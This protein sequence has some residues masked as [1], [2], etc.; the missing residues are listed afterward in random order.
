VL[1]ILKREYWRAWRP[2]SHPP[3][4]PP[5]CVWSPGRKGSLLRSSRPCVTSSSANVPELT[6]RL[7]SMTTQI[8]RRPGVSLCELM[9]HGFLREDDV[10][11][12][13]NVDETRRTRAESLYASW[14]TE[15]RRNVEFP[16]PRSRTQR[17]QTARILTSRPPQTT[18]RAHTARI[19]RSPVQPPP[20]PPMPQPNCP[21]PTTQTTLT[22]TLGENACCICRDRERTHAPYPCF[23]MCLCETCANLVDTCPLCRSPVVTVYRIFT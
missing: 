20:T 21:S 8:A 10:S 13:G 1:R 19:H 18:A 23:H 22:Q 2:N 7:A 6:L 15:Q 17:P 16:R 11:P 12:A 14:L 9:I 5:P 4:P 3:S